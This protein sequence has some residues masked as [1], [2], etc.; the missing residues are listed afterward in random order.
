VAELQNR[1][2][3]RHAIIN[4]SLTLSFPTPT[5]QGYEP[6]E[7]DTDLV[8]WVETASARSVNELFD[9]QAALIAELFEAVRQC[10]RLN[11][12]IVSAAGNDS[13]RA[14][15]DLRAA[16]Y[17]AI[18]QFAVGVGALNRDRTHPADYSNRAD[19]PVNQGLMVVGG[20]YDE[21]DTTI[22]GIIGIFTGRLNL[23][24]DP[25]IPDRNDNAYAEWSGTSFATPVLAGTIAKVCLQQG[26][27]PPAALNLIR[28]RASVD[29]NG[30]RWFAEVWQES[31]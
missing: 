21:S 15:G 28:G 18:T 5:H 22:G 31:G 11:S 17:L 14:Q 10:L 19:F 16:R 2:P 25:S 26:T 29:S 30:F 27:T 24:D 12:V 23:D 20:E 8:E 3:G 9:D 6:S 7:M 13:H 1:H 4:C